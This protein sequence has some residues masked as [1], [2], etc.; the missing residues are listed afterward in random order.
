MP[1]SA[2]STIVVVDDDEGTCRAL[3]RSL[4]CNGYRVRTYTRARDYAL[5]GA[6]LGAVPVIGYVI[7]AVV[8]EAQFVASAIPQAAARNLEW[9]AIGAIVFGACG[10]AV[11][12]AFR[13][14]VKASPS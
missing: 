5:A 6:L 9:G 1:A 3:A 12:L 2:Q 7:V 11:A 4:S 13:A 10:S 8:F 14:V